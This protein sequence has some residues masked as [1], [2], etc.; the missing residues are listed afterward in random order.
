MVCSKT[1]GTTDS[2][3]PP[4]STETNPADLTSEGN[5]HICNL[6]T[7]IHLDC[8][9]IFGLL[10]NYNQSPDCLAVISSITSFKI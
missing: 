7:I 10:F 2:T 3:Y 4:L 5:F 1:L 8:Y 9:L 6:H